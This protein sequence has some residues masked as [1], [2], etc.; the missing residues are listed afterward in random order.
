MP[1]SNTYMPDNGERRTTPVDTCTC[2]IKLVSQTPTMA[3]FYKRTDTIQASA[4]KPD[5]L[6]NL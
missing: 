4:T 5:T 3:M 6:I 1:A 2:A